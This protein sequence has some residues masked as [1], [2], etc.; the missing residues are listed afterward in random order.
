LVDAQITAE[1]LAG[2]ATLFGLVQPSQAPPQAVVDE[3]A[4]QLEQEVAFHTVD[5]ALD[6]EAIVEDAVEDGQADEVVVVGL[7]AAIGHPGAKRLAAATAGGVLCVED[8]QPQD[9]AVGD[10]TNVAIKATVAVAATTA[11]GTGVGLGPA[12]DGDDFLAWLGL[13]A[14]SLLSW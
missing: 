5:S 10:G 4:G 11:A 12:A 6:V 13:D 9:R 7:G 3:A 14:H 2:Q 1:L 8:V